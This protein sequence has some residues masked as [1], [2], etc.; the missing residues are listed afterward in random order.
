MRLAFLVSRMQIRSKSAHGCSYCFNLLYCC[1]QL[2]ETP[3]YAS[4]PKIRL[5]ASLDTKRSNRCSSQQRCFRRLIASQMN[6]HVPDRER[7][8]EVVII[9]VDRCKQEMYSSNQRQTVGGIYGM[10]HSRR[11]Y[12]I[13]KNKRNNAVPSICPTCKAWQPK[14]DRFAGLPSEG[15]LLCRP[16]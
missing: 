9:V 7:E 2:H 10:H 1:R 6:L 13:R 12:Q 14:R 16:R 11:S 3:F 8:A 15:E 5:F 4:I